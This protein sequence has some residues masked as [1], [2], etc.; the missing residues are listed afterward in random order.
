MTRTGQRI[1]LTYG[2]FDIF[3]VGHVR[4]LRRAR[5]LGDF[6]IVGCSTDEFNAEK[7]KKSIFPYEHRQEIL[8]SNEHVDMVIPE[9]SW[10]Q[11][12]NDIRKHQVDVFTMGDDWAGRFDDL[13]GEVDVTY[14]PRTDG[15]STTEVKEIMRSLAED[16]KR[17]ILNAG[18]HLMD[19]LRRL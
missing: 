1:V 15:I 11:K 13:Q 2:T 12:L 19:L 4:L 7:G 16:H 9:K 18:D 17:Q 3:H 14:L 5:R 10:D 8:Q 6:L